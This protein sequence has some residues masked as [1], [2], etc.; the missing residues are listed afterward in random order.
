WSSSSISSSDFIIILLPLFFFTGN[1]RLIGIE[2]LKYRPEV[3]L[4]AAFWPEYPYP[5]MEP[6]FACVFCVACVV[7]VD[8]I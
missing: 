4:C 2:G 1:V 7:D 8:G 3:A 5:D 6:G